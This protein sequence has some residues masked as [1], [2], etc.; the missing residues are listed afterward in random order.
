MIDFNAC[1]SIVDKVS[2]VILILSILMAI[3]S[4]IGVYSN[5]SEE[6]KK[7]EIFREVLGGLDVFFTGRYLNST[8]KKWRRPY[9][10]SILY[11]VMWCLYAHHFIEC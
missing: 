8:G 1:D 10:V 4:G 7:K 6:I 5:E 11:I 3:L 9:L 2:I